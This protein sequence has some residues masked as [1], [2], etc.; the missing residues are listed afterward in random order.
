[1]NVF[2]QKISVSI[3]AATVLAICIVTNIPLANA[4]EISQISLAQTE[5]YLFV[6]DKTSGKIYVFD[7]TDTPTLKTSF[8]VGNGPS[9]L[10]I[11]N[12]QYLLVALSQAK[13]IGVIDMNSLEVVGNIDI[14]KMPYQIGVDGTRLWITISRSYGANYEPLVLEQ[15]GSDILSWTSRSIS[16][17]KGWTV[18]VGNDHLLIDSRGRRAYFGNKGWSPDNI[19]KY[20]ITSVDSPTS[21]MES[22]HGALGSNGQHF[23]LS[24]DGSKIFFASGSP[25]TLQV[26]DT[27]DLTKEADLPLGAYPVAAAIDSS[28]IYAGKAHSINEDIKVFRRSDNIFI[29]EYDFFGNEDLIAKGLSAGK[30]LYA[31]TNKYLYLLSSTDSTV[32]RIYDFVKDKIYTPEPPPAPPPIPTPVPTPQPTPTPIPTPEPVPTPA[33]TIIPTPNPVPTPAPAPIPEQ[34]DELFD[35]LIHATVK[36]ICETEN[37]RIYGSGTIVNENGTILTNRHVVEVEQGK[38]A[39]VCYVGFTTDLDQEPDFTDV[40]IPVKIAPDEDIIMLS[41]TNP[42]RTSYPSIN[43]DETG[44]PKKLKL[45]NKIQVLG[46]P[47]VG[48]TKLTYS[49]GDFSGFGSAKN[50]L[51]NYLKTTAVI[52]QGNSGGGAYSQ[53]GQFIG[54]PTLV[55]SGKIGSIGYLLSI[56]K[57]KKWLSDENPT[58]AA[59]KEQMATTKVSLRE[60]REQLKTN[61]DLTPP[62][63]NAAKVKAQIVKTKR[64]K[65]IISGVIDDSAIAGYYMYFGSDMRANPVVKGKFSKK[66]VFTAR[67]PIKTG[68]YYFIFAAKDKNKNLSKP[69]VFEYLLVK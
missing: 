49:S 40:A 6:A 21:L 65:F 29:R 12:N 45:G 61:A 23:I 2:L 22:S 51:G 57:I 59:N 1:M 67:L 3:V 9:H 14:P 66:S 58:T 55:V 36:L 10:A 17:A 60:L 24:E 33:P 8:L 15:N 11:Y 50:N 62:D 19:S 44:D 34:T 30:H 25:Y 42:T 26:I 64:L 52:E 5:Q 13:K 69:Y 20:D 48:G 16:W 32:T 27:N 31:V 54:I 35:K 63:I 4:A 68:R 53:S 47:D 46:Y 41:I 56:N 39:P 18:F 7:N 28:N 38:T 37:V 43:F